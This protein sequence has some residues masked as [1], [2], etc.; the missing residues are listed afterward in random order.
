MKK[1]ASAAF[2]GQL[3]DQFDNCPQTGWALRMTPY[4]GT[5]VVVHGVEIEAG[6]A[7]KDDVVDGKWVVLFHHINTAYIQPRVVQRPLRRLD[8][9]LGHI[10]FLGA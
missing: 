4:Q 5:A 2:Q 1:A 3:L 6:F 9:G 7:A 10:A 8:R